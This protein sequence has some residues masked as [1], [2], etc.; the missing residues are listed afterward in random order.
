[1]VIFKNKQTFL[2]ITNE[3][4]NN[5]DS[6]FFYYPQPLDTTEIA[7]LFI[8]AVLKYI[9]KLFFLRPKRT[10]F[11]QISANFLSPLRLIL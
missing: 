3:F 10:Y 9:T 5:Q 8:I 7:V 2:R 1:L 11:Q 6:K 4:K